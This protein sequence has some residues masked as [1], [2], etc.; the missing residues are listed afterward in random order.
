MILVLLPQRENMSGFLGQQWATSTG[1][2]SERSVR[3]IHI[4]VGHTVPWQWPFELKPDLTHAWQLR[5][6]TAPENYR[7]RQSCRITKR[8]EGLKRDAKDNEE[9]RKITKRHEGHE[10]AR[11]QVTGHSKS[12]KDNR[13]A[14]ERH[15]GL[16]RDTEQIDRSTVVYTRQL[17]CYAETQRTT[18]RH[19]WQLGHREFIKDTCFAAESLKGLR[20]DTKPTNRSSESAK[21]VCLS[22]KIHIDYEETRTQVIGHR[23]SVKDN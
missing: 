3:S 13:L 22:A 9:T 6:L 20:R 23:K 18:K 21:N 12:I 19:E 16:R 7:G 5:W 10:K 17:P 4:T 2:S 14:V 11:S 8:H 1:Q 15:K